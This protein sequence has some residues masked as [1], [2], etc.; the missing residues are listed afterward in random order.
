MADVADYSDSGVEVVSDVD[1]TQ[2]LGCGPKNGFSSSRTDIP[3]NIAQGSGYGAL[4][5]SQS[6]PTCPPLP[7]PW[8]RLNSDSLSGCD[9]DERTSL[10]ETQLRAGRGKG[11]TGLQ[12]KREAKSGRGARSSR[13]QQLHN[14]QELFEEGFIS[15]EEY[16]QRKQQLVDTLTGTSIATDAVSKTPNQPFI[17]YSSKAVVPHPPPDFSNFQ[18]AE[19]LQ[20]T[21]D[22][23]TGVWSERYIKVQLDPQPFAKGGLR[24]AFHMAVVGDHHRYVAKCSIDP[25]E[26]IN[27]YYQ[28]VELQMY[29][30]QWAEKYN[31]YNPPKRVHFIP[32]WLMMVAQEPSDGSDIR[33]VYVV[34]RYIEGVY[35]KH[36]NNAGFVDPDDRNTPQAFSHFTY[37]ASNHSVL[38]CDIQG[39]ADVYTDPQLHTI[40]GWGFG[41][42]NLGVRGFDRFLQSHRCNAI[43]HY[44]RL[45]GVNKKALDV[46][47]VPAQRIMERPLEAHFP[48]LPPHVL[49]DS[50]YNTQTKSG[51]L[52]SCCCIL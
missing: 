43:C 3:S 2:H 6:G 29:C 20:Q 4:V 10:L 39:V 8:R 46:G 30:T 40:D 1:S 28:D 51:S 24:L 31:S 18:E 34:E 48:Q 47:T 45:P 50:D 37:E 23:K 25:Y 44:L 14:L 27:A 15:K 26:D 21:F 49:V 19:A 36:N 9:S 13:W 11:T 5:T 12:R 16:A 35:R 7:G 22:I 52:F 33:G 42:G 17:S 41:K 38:V 32:A